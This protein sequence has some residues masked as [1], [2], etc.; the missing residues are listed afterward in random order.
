M[1]YQPRPR[2][3]VWIVPVSSL[4]GRLPLIPAGDTGT[5]PHSM[6]GRMDMCYPGGECD[7]VDKP[8]TG[9]ALYY[10]NSWAMVFPL[11]ILQTENLNSSSLLPYQQ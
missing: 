11:T 8:G 9:S 2:S 10:I 5:I 1:P 4:L 3:R 7:N 6:H